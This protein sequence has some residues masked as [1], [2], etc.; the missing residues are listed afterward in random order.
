M[1]TTPDSKNPTF[2]D[3]NEL[4]Q[5]RNLLAGERTLLAWI[6]T[7][8]SMITFGFV[9][10]QYFHISSEAFEHPIHFPGKWFGFTMICMG[11]VLPLFAVV[12]HV[13]RVGRLT[14]DDLSEHPVRNLAVITG[15]LLSLLGFAGVFIL[16][17]LVN[18]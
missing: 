9:L 7:S 1:T 15:I 17:V 3:Q 12:Q 10:T 6:R 2:R 18:I 11:T 13:A 16:L 5:E 4:A 8:L 14:V